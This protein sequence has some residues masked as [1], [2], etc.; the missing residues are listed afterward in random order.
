MQ[1]EVA[2]WSWSLFGVLLCLC[3]RRIRA[4]I[5]AGGLA[6]L[7]L[8]AP[9]R[10]GWIDAVLS[11]SLN[12]SLLALL[13]AT[14]FGL[15]LVL[16]RV[17]RRTMRTVL[18]WLMAGAVG[19]VA[20]V[21]IFARDTNSVVVLVA[22]IVAVVLWRLPSTWRTRKWAAVLVCLLPAVAL[23]SIW[24]A[25]R[26]PSHYPK[27]WDEWSRVWA[28]TTPRGQF[29]LFNNFFFRIFH[30]DK[31][32]EFFLS[33][34][35]PRPPDLEVKHRRDLPGSLPKPYRKLLRERSF[36]PTRDWLSQHGTRTYALWLLRHPVDRVEEFVRLLGPALLA[37]PLEKYMPEGWKGDDSGRPVIDLLR[38][39]PESGAVALLLLMLAPL[40]F[41]APL[42]HPMSG[43]A[44]CT[45]LAGAFGIGIA[46][47]G[48]ALEIPRHCQ[49]HSQQIILGLFL[50][51]L[52]KLDRRSTEARG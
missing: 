4:R 10:L 34:G 1:R 20:M 32:Y 26:V 6:F 41:R 12:D 27:T 47:Y 30:D 2:F 8:L 18:T 16:E 44:L 21:W 39:L 31:A 5:A 11:E 22:V 25:T 15:V 40:L 43:I 37:P 50:A 28:P 51:V 36:K 49:P 14:G 24:T 19:A 38:F 7:F 17:Q 33:R 42:A 9:Y 35:M 3:L 46:F 23:F 45:V 52:A 29:T 48:D 13:F